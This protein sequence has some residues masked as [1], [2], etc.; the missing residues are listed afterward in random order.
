MRKLNLTSCKGI[1][2]EQ[3]ENS[4]S[5]M[6]NLEA[7]CVYHDGYFDG[8]FKKL[9]SLCKKLKTLIWLP[10][11]HF[12][13]VFRLKNLKSITTG[14]ETGVD[15]L[16][17]ELV[18]HNAETL[19]TLQIDRGPISKQTC[20]TISKLKRLKTLHLP[21]GSTLNRSSLRCFSVL[22]NLIEFVK[23]LQTM[24]FYIWYKH[25]IN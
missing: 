2:S 16:L 5:V 8:V 20:I 10:V 25:V 7:L 4:L 6:V 18:V 19:E 9:P 17:H 3:L 1:E 24:I 13:G 14:C 12:N 15:E 22:E 11:I 21:Y 23:I